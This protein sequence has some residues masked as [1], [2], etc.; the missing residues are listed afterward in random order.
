[1]HKET[2]LVSWGNSQA[3]RIPHEIVKQLNLKNNQKLA[4]DIKGDSIVLTPIQK[5][6]QDIHELFQNWEDDGIRE[7]ELDWGNSQGNELEW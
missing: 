5:K 4:I 1:M 3:T 6:P 7:K 2:K